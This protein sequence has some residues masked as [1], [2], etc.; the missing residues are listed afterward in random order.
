MK[1]TILEQEETL[2]FIHTFF[3]HIKEQ[4]SWAIIENVLKVVDRV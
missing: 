3:T 2:D 1:P 4:S